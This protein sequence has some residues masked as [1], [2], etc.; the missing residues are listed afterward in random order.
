MTASAQIGQGTFDGGGLFGG[1]DTQTL[2]FYDETGNNP[3]PAGIEVS[4]YNANGGPPIGTLQPAGALIGTAWTEPGGTCSIIVPPGTLL[5]ATFALSAQA[6]DG[7]VEFTPDGQT[8][9]YEVIVPGYRSNSLSTVGYTEAQMVKLVRGWFGPQAKSP[10][11]DGVAPSGEAWAIGYGFAA[12]LDVLDAQIQKVL[13]TMRLQSCVGGDIDSWSLDMVG[14]TF[15]RYPQESDALFIA[16][17]K[18][19]VARPRTTI[20]AIF[21]LVTAFYNSILAGWNVVGNEA[22]SF[23]KTGGFDTSGGFDNPP[24]QPVPKQ[25]PPIMV[26]DGMTNASFASQL[27]MVAGQFCI[28]VGL[29]AT[30]L[31]EQLAFNTAGAFGGGAQGANPGS[32]S[33][34][35][36]VTTDSLPT[37]TLIAPDPRLGVMVNLIAKAGG[38]TPLYLVGQI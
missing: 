20:D 9:A 19:M 10:S 23:D 35:N 21:N 24:A 16:R 33:F 11:P 3:L 26:F 37:P 6:P 27:G 34:S 22:L 4:V 29:F 7:Y 32:G 36:N 15:G 17:N 12:A 38:T 14:P 1:V 31:L 28:A 2:V 25:P 13:S 8:A 5:I 30:S 18:L